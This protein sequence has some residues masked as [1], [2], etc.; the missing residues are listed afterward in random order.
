[1]R[2][3]FSILSLFA[4]ALI[5]TVS[6]AVTADQAEDDAYGNASEENLYQTTK[7][8][9]AKKQEIEQYRKQL[10]YDAVRENGEIKEGAPL[11]LKAV[12]CPKL[13]DVEIDK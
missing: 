7:L 3:K 9:E 6:L 13:V 2:S 10:V 11:F 5:L 4:A 8:S 12:H 1:M